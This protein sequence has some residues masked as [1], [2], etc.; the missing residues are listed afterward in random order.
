M[1]GTQSPDV[2]GE[3]DEDGPAAMVGIVVGSRPGGDS[4]YPPGIPARGR[5]MLD[6]L[7]EPLRL[8]DS[9]REAVRQALHLILRDM[10]ASGAIVL[11][12]REDHWSKLDGSPAERVAQIAGRLQE[13]EM[14]ELWKARRP[15]DWPECPDHPGTHPLDPDVNDNDV[16]IWR[17]PRSRREMSPIGQLG[18]PDTRSAV[19]QTIGSNAPTSDNSQLRPD[20]GTYSA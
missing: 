10:R 12:Y 14:E 20:L 4:A 5:Q 1:P 18:S 11:D 9:E 16:A 15:T 8:S 6:R 3:D 2:P 17:C 19:L 7:H 13:W